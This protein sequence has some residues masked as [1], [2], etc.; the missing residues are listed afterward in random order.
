MKS[1]KVEQIA[2]VLSRKLLGKSHDRVMMAYY[3]EKLPSIRFPRTAEEWEEGIPVRHR[4]WAP[5][6][7][8]W[9]G[10]WSRSAPLVR[11]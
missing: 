9:V 4:P 6:A 3:R 11:A 8:F 5:E 10:R 2:R 1:L 7:G